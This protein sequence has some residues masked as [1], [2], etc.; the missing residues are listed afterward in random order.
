MTRRRIALTALLIMLVAVAAACGGKA[1]GAPSG[2]AAS[3]A[4]QKD[5]GA[6]SVTLEVTWA[7]PAYVAEDEKLRP[8]AESRAGEDVVLL[9]VKMNTHSVDLSKYD[10]AKIS[11]LDGGGGPEPAIESVTI[12]D[13]Q[14]HAEAVLIFKRP[15]KASTATLIV[16]EIGGVPE[17]TL[18]WSPPP[19]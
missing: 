16:R 15:A 3:S 18:R 6:G 10:L 8:I 7:T 2:A 5:D 12:S 14:H 17:R 1:S 13:D 19:S 11:T 4:T 9:H